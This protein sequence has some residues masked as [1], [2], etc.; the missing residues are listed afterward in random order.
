M[1]LLVRLALAALVGAAQEDS[2]TAL[3]PAAAESV[4]LSPS[5]SPLP[6]LIPSPS[7]GPGVT[8]AVGLREAAGN[9]TPGN[10]TAGV[11]AASP[12]GAGAV[13]S[14]PAGAATVVGSEIAAG[15]GAAEGEGTCRSKVLT[16]SDEWCEATCKPGGL[17]GLEAGHFFFKIRITKK[18]L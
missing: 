18:N 13:G 17:T 16:I 11:G 4:V 6:A 14:L 5:P 15:L 8:G 9:K 2:A 10:Q 1:R 12:A 3:Q 7:P